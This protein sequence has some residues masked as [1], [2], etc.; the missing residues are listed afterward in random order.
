[1]E[2]KKRMGRFNKVSQTIENIEDEYTRKPKKDQGTF[3]QLF[4]TVFL[5]LYQYLS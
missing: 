4:E 5:S 1:M 2:N 3:L